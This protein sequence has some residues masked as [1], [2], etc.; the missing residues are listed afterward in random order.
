MDENIQND[1]FTL[2]VSGPTNFSQVCG[3]FEQ[4]SAILSFVSPDSDF[5][6]RECTESEIVEHAAGWIDF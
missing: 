6:I 2:V 4:A 1:V 3:T 5:E